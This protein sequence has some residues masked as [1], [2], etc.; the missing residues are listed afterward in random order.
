[1]VSLIS[2]GREIVEKPKTSLLVVLGRFGAGGMGKGILE[3]KT[4]VCGV[5]RS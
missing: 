1:M 3:K 2:T 4:T 5:C